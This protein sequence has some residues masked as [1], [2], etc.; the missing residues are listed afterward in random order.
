MKDIELAKEILLK[1]DFALVAVKNGE[2][3]LNQMKRV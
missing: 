1:E 3:I 2:I